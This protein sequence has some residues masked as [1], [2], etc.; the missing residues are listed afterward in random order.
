[1]GTSK[2]W[3]RLVGMVA[4]IA[5]VCQAQ[6]GPP[7]ARDRVRGPL[8]TVRLGKA[9]GKSGA[10]ATVLPC[11]GGEGVLR[12]D[13]SALPEGARVHRADLVVFRSRE[14]AGTDPDRLVNVTIHPLLGELRP[15]SAAIVGGERLRLRGPWFDRLDATEAVRAWA[16]G[17]PN[18]GFFVKAFPLWDRQRSRLDVTYE[19]RPKA[20]PAQAKGLKVF[21]RAGQTFITWKEI[22]DPV[23]KDEI[24]WGE[25]RGILSSLDREREV[26]YCVY[27]GSKPI[28]AKSLAGAECLARVEPLSCWNLNA[29]NKA[30][31]RDEV[32]AALLSSEH[33]VRFWVAGRRGTP[34]ECPIDRFVIEDGGARGG[35]AAPLARGTGLYVHTVRQKARAYYA[36]VTMVDGVQNTADFGKANARQRPV[37]EQPAGPVPVLQGKLPRRPVWDYRHTRYQ[38]VRW[39]SSPYGNLPCR[40]YNWLVCVPDRPGKTCPVEL[41]LPQPGNSWYRAPYRIEQDSIVVVPHDFPLQTWYYGYHESEGTLRSFRQGVFHNYTQRR[42]LSFL[43]WVARTWPA[44]RNRIAVAGNRLVAGSGALHL[45]LRHH[46][47]FNL[48]MTGYG[49]V[50]FRGAIRKFRELGPIRKVPGVRRTFRAKCPEAEIEKLLG[51]LDWDLKTGAGAG[52]P[53][54]VWDELDLTRRV[55]SLPAATDL[56]VVTYAGK[57]GFEAD[58]DFRLAML[59]KGHLLV[60]DFNVYGNRL[61]IPISRT[62]ALTG[63]ISADVRKDLSHPAFRGPGAAVLLRP[64]QLATGELVVSDGT[65]QWWGRFNHRYRWSDVLD[66]PG[67]YEITLAWRGRGA[68]T[69]D[70]V[71][72]RLQRFRAQAGK[73]CAWQFKAALADGK[74]ISQSGEVKPDEGLLRIPQVRIA[75]EP[76][77]L[78]VTT[79]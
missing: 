1:M 60:A 19:G 70:V 52:D 45:G 4:S 57:G 48:V 18:G 35:A 7:D 51:R 53:V 25:M 23:G 76:G 15:G 75:R 59:D 66:Q 50:D 27:R 67:R 8:A 65:L 22:S 74:E 32:V 16:A 46:R 68:G 63:M 38:Y 58:R 78:V 34:D 33:P 2:R 37:A 49:C 9:S 5:S 36:V 28:D 17:K 20:V 10:A 72:R 73:T 21:H 41:N 40:Y 61:F 11:K 55:R 13:L 43:E 12:F 39:V 24:R 29:R 3:I 44:D 54:S 26:R 47:V 6:A 14:L 69:S 79:K 56:P 30:R 64:P 62:G 71:L 31:P 77:R 42:M